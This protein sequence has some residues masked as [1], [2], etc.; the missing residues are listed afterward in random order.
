MLDLP[1]IAAAFG[2]DTPCGVSETGALCTDPS[3]RPPLRFLGVDSAALFNIF[4]SPP[5]SVSFSFGFGDGAIIN[6][7]EEDAATVSGP[8]IGLPP[9]PSLLSD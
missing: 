3:P 7:V 5:P 9:V 1:F 8:A 2:V 4:F 6:R